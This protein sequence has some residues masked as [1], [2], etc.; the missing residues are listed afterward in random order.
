ML[1]V[2]SKRS[3]ATMSSVQG[4]V[5]G[6]PEDSLAG[7]AIVACLYSNYDGT[8]A[9]DEGYCILGST[10]QDVQQQTG[11]DADCGQD[12]APCEDACEAASESSITT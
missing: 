3:M 5:S 4:L 6:A 9:V 10:T 2:V 11:L 1:S 12:G 8:D 7:S